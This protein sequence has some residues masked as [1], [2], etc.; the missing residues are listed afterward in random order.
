VKRG[1]IL[2]WSN[3]LYTINYKTLV[4]IF[5]CSVS[6]ECLEHNKKK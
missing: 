3:G 6:I 5:V 2:N 1:A 4:I